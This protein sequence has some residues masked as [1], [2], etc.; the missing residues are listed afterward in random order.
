MKLDGLNTQNVLQ[1]GAD[2]KD[3]VK[4]VKK[5]LFLIPANSNTSNL[6]QTAKV[7]RLKQQINGIKDD[8]DYI[9][10]DVNP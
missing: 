1:A 4:Q 9:I 5:N 8:Y 3:S 7:S 2:I 6:S 10:I